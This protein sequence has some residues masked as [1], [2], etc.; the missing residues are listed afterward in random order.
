M[1]I[2]VWLAFIFGVVFLLIS[3][4]FALFAF[5]LPK[6]ANPEAVGNFLFVLQV[7]LA[8]AGS[9]VA[10]V[11]PGFLSVRIQRQLEREERMVFAPVGLWQCS[12]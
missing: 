11:I 12:Y 10:A 1:K 3:L 9:G 7:V 8:L 6:P 5:Y 2:E 4:L